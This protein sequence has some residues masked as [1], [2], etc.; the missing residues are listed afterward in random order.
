MFNVS[1]SKAFRRM[2][3]SVSNH[4][5]VLKPPSYHEIPVKYLKEV[6]TTKDV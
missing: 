6:R 2:I 1:R 4:S 3:D 5:P